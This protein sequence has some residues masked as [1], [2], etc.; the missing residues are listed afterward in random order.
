VSLLHFLVAAAKGDRN[1]DSDLIFLC[2][3]ELNQMS[4]E[5]GPGFF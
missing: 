2:Q 3:V 5:I 1:I 4:V